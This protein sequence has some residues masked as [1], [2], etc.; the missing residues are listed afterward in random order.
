VHHH[1]IGLINLAEGHNLAGNQRQRVHY[2][3]R[4]LKIGQEKGVTLQLDDIYKGLSEAYSRLGND[5]KAL[6]FYKDYIV[7][8]DSV[9]NDKNKKNVTELELKYQTA[10]QEKIISEK[11]LQLTQRNLQLQKS[12]QYFLYSI[13]GAIVAFLIAGLIYNNLRNKKK[14]HA[15]Q[16]YTIQQEKEIQLLQAIMQ[17]E[18]KERSRIA[19]DLHD[20]VAG[21]LAAVKMHFTSMALRIGGVLQTEGYHQGIKL[22]D[23]ATF[24]IR[25]TSH[26]LMPEVLLQ[27]GLD[28]AL[29]RYCSSISNTHSL[30]VQYDS[31]GEIG[32]YKDSFELSVYRV[33][34]E[35]LNNIVK[36]SKAKQALVQ[37]SQENSVLSITVEDNGIGFSND[38]SDMSGMGL[39]SLKARVNAING[40]IELNAEPGSGVSAYLEFETVGLKKEE[41]V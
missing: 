11:Q 30:V 12:K 41:L 3:Q 17:G 33:V 23:E 26:N 22:L 40:K 36:H 28:K 6:N 27:H 38:N 5:T 13:G 34:Q 35:L 16:L 20:G 7:Y 19:K 37:V 10:R 29:Q 24:E 8:R 21:M 14:A 4:S 39:K 18:E 1:L 32:R 9:T 15:R 31:W 2:L 25:K